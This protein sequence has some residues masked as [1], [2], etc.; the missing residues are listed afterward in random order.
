MIVTTAWTVS[1]STIL[2]QFEGLTPLLANIAPNLES[3][4]TLVKMEQT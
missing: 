2:Y 1:G 3:Y 4:A